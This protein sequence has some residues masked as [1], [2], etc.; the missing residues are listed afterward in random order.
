MP[1]NHKW[2]SMLSRIRRVFAALILLAFAAA[3]ARAQTDIDLQLVL[4]VDASGSVSMGR[5]DLQKQGYAAAFRDPRVIKAIRSGNA[6]AIAITMFQW[7]GPTLHVPVVPWM[8]IK[9]EASAAAA[10]RAIEKTER[11]LFGGGTSISGAIDFAMTLMPQKQFRPARR[12][13]DVSGDGANTSGRP[14]EIARDQTVR[15][16]VTINGLP[17]LALDATLDRYYFDHVIG[18]PGSFM[19]PAANYDSFAEAIV[20]KLIME[21]AGAAGARQVARH[22]GARTRIGASR[23]PGTGSARTRNP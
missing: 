6:G 3:P 8:L 2:S 14:V 21:I 7:T 11:Q 22:S 23:R 15:A 18:G 1:A 9:D 19:I 20:K 17:I 16:G 10:A 13:I 12:V 4:A 5:F